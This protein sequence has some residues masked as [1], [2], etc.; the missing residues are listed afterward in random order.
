MKFSEMNFNTFMARVWLRVSKTARWMG[1][2]AQKVHLA[3]VDFAIARAQKWIDVEEKEQQERN[4]Y[5]AQKEQDVATRTKELE[6][7]DQEIV[8]LTEEQQALEKEL[9]QK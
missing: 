7:K 9:E 1:D 3:V 4:D 5:I 8:K 6:R 2:V